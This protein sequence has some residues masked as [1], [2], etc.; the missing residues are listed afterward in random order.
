MALPAHRVAWVRE[1]EFRR[2]V[3]GARGSEVVAALADPAFAANWSGWCG[4]N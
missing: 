1:A 4:K 3:P 2:L